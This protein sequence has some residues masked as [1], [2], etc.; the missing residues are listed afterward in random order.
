MKL[1]VFQNYLRQNKLD[2]ACFIYSEQCKDYGL[3]Y[4]TQLHPSYGI[5]LITPKT[6]T[7][8]L[9]ALDKHPSLPG[10][11]VARITPQW[12]ELFSRMNV[13]RVG[14]HKSSLTVH[15]LETLQTLWKKA[16]F[17]DLTGQLILL[18]QQKTK[19]EIQKITHACTITTNSL[20]ALCRELPHKRLKTEQDA[21][22][23]L[24]KY[25]LEH[26]CG[27]AFPTI[28]AMGANA[29]IP[30]HHT[31]STP[32]R[33]GFLLIDFGASYQNYNADCTRVLYLGTPS[34]EERK[35]YSL[36]LDA[37]QAG[38]AAVQEGE[39][40]LALD[41]CVRT[42]LGREQKNFIHSLGHGIGLEVH[43][44]PVFSSPEA[45]ITKDMVFTIEPGIYFPG[46]LGLRIEDTL[47]WDGKK[48]RILTTFPKELITIPF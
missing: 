42:V 9:T 17:V 37:Q 45:V 14:I 4:F 27:V 43:E 20:R 23:F 30:H 29:A 34:G 33:K 10:I 48:A 2:V 47:W 19:E 8:Y 11:K 13:H 15:S 31:S 5:L 36:L 12:K 22:F 38:V 40:F 25:F 3:T 16:S 46:R 35:H 28:V 32:L 26:G 41:K 39:S 7:L 44:A 24:E 1:A 21:A 6:A 18:R